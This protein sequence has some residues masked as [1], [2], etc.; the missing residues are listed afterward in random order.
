MATDWEELEKGARKYKVGKSIA[1][2]RSAIKEK[3]WKRPAK[4]LC[5]DMGQ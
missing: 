3:K 5:I 4:V 2:K 1:R